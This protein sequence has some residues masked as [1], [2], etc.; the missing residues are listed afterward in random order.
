MADAVSK[1]LPHRDIVIST[2][3]YEYG[4]AAPR[5]TKPASNVAIKVTANGV[6]YGAPLSDPRNS[7]F[8]DDLVAW[9]RITER[10]YVWNYINDAGCYLQSW[11]NW[12]GCTTIHTAVHLPRLTPMNAR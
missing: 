12:Y 7:D 6:H 2:L 11:P 3:A 4:R 5:I 10:L 1:E 8:A 9:G